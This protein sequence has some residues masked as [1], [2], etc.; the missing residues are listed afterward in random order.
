MFFTRG[1]PVIY[2]GDEQGFTGD[3]G[4]KLARQDMFANA[5]PEYGDDDL[6]GTDA[7]TDDDNFDQTH[8]IYQALAEFARVY[9]EHP[10]LRS[11]AQIHRYSTNEPGVYA[12]SR[13]DRV[14]K[15]E[16]VVAFNNA[17]TAI[18][19]ATIATYAPAGTG[20]ELILS[21]GIGPGRSSRRW[22]PAP[23]D[24]DVPGLGLSRCTG[25]LAPPIGPTLHAQ[26]PSPSPPPPPVHSPSGCRTS[27]GT[28]LIDRIEVSATLDS[29]RLRRGHVRRQR[30]R[31]GVRTDRHR[32]QRPLPGLLRRRSG[33]PDGASLSF[34]AIANDLF[35]GLSGDTVTGVV[36]AID[37][38]AGA[39]GRRVRLRRHPLPARR[40]RLRRPLHRQLPGLLGPPPV[41]RHRRDDRMDRAQTVR[42]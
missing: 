29:R 11:G 8:P 7:T 13:I 36:P 26:H 24:L 2:Y 35:G 30:R 31:W 14:E 32:R 9:Q 27:T 6:L 18:T 5:V 1:Q 23:S 15:V 40:R 16:Y 20:F 17:G 38:G 12:F 21:Q 4:D 19:A 10:A 3:G 39:A 41:G 22:P 42:R 37:P 34:K 25:P 33:L 28:T